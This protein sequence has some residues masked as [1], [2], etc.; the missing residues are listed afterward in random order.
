HSTRDWTKF[1]GPINMQEIGTGGEKFDQSIGFPGEVHVPNITP[2]HL[3]NWTDGEIFRAVTSG[4][5]KDGSAIFPIMPYKHY[6]QMDK[7]DIYSIIAYIRTL[8]EKE[9][10]T[11]QRKLD[12]PLN[13]LV[14]TMPQKA[15]LNTIPL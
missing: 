10:K 12:F 3:K 6:G 4:V 11:P 2:F 8:P 7:E 5:K 14:N 15:S 13:L 9:S 1:S